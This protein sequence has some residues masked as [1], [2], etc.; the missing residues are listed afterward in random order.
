MVA[1]FVWALMFQVFVYLLECFCVAD[2]DS[3]SWRWQRVVGWTT[4]GVRSPE[5]GT[6][7]GVR[8]PEAGFPCTE[9]DGVLLLKSDDEVCRCVSDR[10]IWEWFAVVLDDEVEGCGSSPMLERN[11]SRSL[12]SC[13]IRSRSFCSLQHK[14]KDH[15]KTSNISHTK[16]QNLKLPVSLWSCLCPIHWSQ[17]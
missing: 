14:R 2:I 16:S 7:W 8:S 10:S 3:W 1:I 4:W 12:N 15:R 5:V 6:T 9:A 13:R 11:F 17:V